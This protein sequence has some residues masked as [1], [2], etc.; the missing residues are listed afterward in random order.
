[1]YKKMVKPLA[2]GVSRHHLLKDQPLYE[3][4]DDVSRSWE[5]A[6]QQALYEKGGEKVI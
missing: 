2:H 3:Q 1:M 5:N 6:T 4:S